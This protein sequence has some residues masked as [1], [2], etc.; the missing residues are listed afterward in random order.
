MHGSLEDYLPDVC[1]GNQIQAEFES[2]PSVDDIL[3]RFNIDRGI[4]QFVL[5]DGRYIE[6]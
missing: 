5:A 6:L 4:L 2:R 3:V 1:Q